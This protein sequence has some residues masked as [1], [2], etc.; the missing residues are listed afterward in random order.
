MKRTPC[1]AAWLFCSGTL[2]VPAVE[3]EEEKFQGRSQ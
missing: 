2:G 3:A 1:A